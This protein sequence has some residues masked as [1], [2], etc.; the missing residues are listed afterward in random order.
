MSEAM[1]LHE[2]REAGPRP[3]ASASQST[4]DGA[5][6]LRA[7]LESADRWTRRFVREHPVASIAVVAAAGFIVGRIAAR[8]R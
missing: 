1:D 3:D 2:E 6:A 8:H 5:E 7:R 4:R